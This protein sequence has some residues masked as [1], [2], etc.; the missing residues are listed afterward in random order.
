ML[1]S[2]L[3]HVRMHVCGHARTPHTRDASP[4]HRSRSRQITSQISVVSDHMDMMTTC[5]A[6]CRAA[7]LFRVNTIPAQTTWLAL[8]CQN[9][10]ST[11]QILVYSFNL[12]R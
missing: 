8:T 1:W 5:V 10:Y 9:N 4:S 7:G 11:G 12:W 3:M 2:G 6:D